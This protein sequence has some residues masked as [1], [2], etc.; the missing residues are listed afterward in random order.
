[1][2]CFFT[3]IGDLLVIYVNHAGFRAP[4]IIEGCGL[5]FEGAG[6]MWKGTRTRG[7]TLDEGDPAG[8]LRKVSM[9]SI[10]QP[11]NSLCV[12]TGAFESCRNIFFRR[13]HSLSLPT[14]TQTGKH[15]VSPPTP[16]LAYNNCCDTRTLRRTIEIAT[17]QLIECTAANPACGSSCHPRRVYVGKIRVGGCFPDVPMEEP[18]RLLFSKPLR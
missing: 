13:P 18:T 11:P 4:P 6:W 15:V 3:N 16:I 9:I 8:A 5:R 17:V 12:T 1:M 2:T 10:P 14:T 7:E